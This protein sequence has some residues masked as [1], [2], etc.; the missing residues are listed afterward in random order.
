MQ[1]KREGDYKMKKNY[2][3]DFITRQYML[4]KDFEI[5]YYS[6]RHLGSMDSHF[7]NYYEVYFFLEGNVSILIRDKLFPL[8]AGDVVVL[9]PGVPHKAVIHDENMPYSR[10]VFWISMDYLQ[11][12]RKMSDD[13]YYIIQCAAEKKQYIYHNEPVPFTALQSKIFH[14]IEEIHSERFGKEPKVF[15]SICDLLLQLNRMAYEQ[16]NPRK[17]REDQDLYHNLLDY[18]DNHLEQE[19]SLDSL[20]KTFYVSKFHIAHIFKEN[21][22]IAIHQYIMKKRLAACQDAILSNISISKA[23]LMF[24]F[25]DYSNFYRAF[26]KE[27]GISP[28]E[29]RD[30]KVQ[31]EAREH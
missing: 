11:Q 6:D 1:R 24:G 14:L 28:K 7:H 20:A 29:Y 9:P 30:M 16:N 8:K 5:Y 4:S 2:K 19:I 21:T 22:G 31:I 12:V 3:T 18:I 17:R 15:I 27:F 13:Y 23:Y 10:F 26:K 25:K